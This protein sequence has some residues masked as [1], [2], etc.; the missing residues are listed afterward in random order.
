[1]GQDLE[2]CLSAATSL[3]GREQVLEAELA[4]SQGVWR[5]SSVGDGSQGVTTVFIGFGELVLWI[6]GSG[7]I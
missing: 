5:R 1:M 3:E 6:R 4:E 7:F 2:S